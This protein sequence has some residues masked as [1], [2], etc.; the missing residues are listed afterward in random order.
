MVRNGGCVLAAVSLAFAIAGCG[1]SKKKSEA[2]RL[3]DAVVV[4][5]LPSDQMSANA[6]QATVVELTNVMFRKTGVLPQVC[7]KLPADAKAVICLGEAARNVSGVDLSDLRNCDWRIK[8]EPGR[9]YLLGKTPYAINAAMVEFCERFCDVYFI[10]LEGD[11]PCE[12]DPAC[13]V[14]VCDVTVRPAIYCRSIYHGMYEK[15]HYPTTNV[16][17][18]NW[19][20]WSRLRRAEITRDFEGACRVSFQVPQCHSQFYYAHPDKYFKEH[21]EYYS[22][23]RTGRRSAVIDFNSQLCYTSGECL[24]TCYHSLVAFVE[25]DRKRHPTNYPCIYDFS[26]HDNSFELCRCSNC[27][28]VAAKYNRVPGG[29]DKGGDAGLQLEFVNKLAR[30]IRDRY[31]DVQL[32][33]MAY[34][35]TECPPKEG[36]IRPEPNVVVWWCDL[37][38]LSDHTLPLATA[39]HFNEKLADELDGWLALSK[40]VQVWDYMLNTHD[41]PEV[42]PDAIAADARLF[43]KRGISSIFMETEYRKQPFYLLNAFLMSE[44]YINPNLD[45]DALIRTY[46]RIYGAAAREMEEAI[47]LLRR[48]NAGGRAADADAWHNRLLPWLTRENLEAVAA[49]LQKAHDKRGLS[50]SERSRISLALASTWKQIVLILKSDPKA[51][52]EFAVAQ[53]AW[54]RYEK[55]FVRDG[56][57]EE[58]GRKKSAAKVDEELELLTLKFRDLPAELK[59][60][61]EKDLVCVD[62]HHG[63]PRVSD[64]VSERGWAVATKIGDNS[65]A[66]KL[67]MVCGTYDFVAKKGNNYKVEK[68][69]EGGSYSWV[70]LG[71]ATIGRNTNFWFPGSWQSFFSLKGYHIL[72]DGLAEDPNRYVVW[73]SARLKDGR[74]Y[75]DRLV[76]HRVKE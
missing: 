15:R 73:A 8:A 44:L 29:F 50:V 37:Y 19:E 26:Q 18:R 64:P 28:K 21:P 66:G 49:L 68:L 57:M 76:F 59:A 25:A 60:V 62:Y 12:P 16:T 22:M 53:S 30:R 65:F 35:S 11:D 5:T 45:V 67:P 34:V 58:S 40:N 32:R 48:M 51:A 3:A 56:F 4:R 14:P 74:V 70:R 47:Q 36:T 33:I 24:E 43:A 9:V 13:A 41:F 2:I 10:T 1:D 39:G 20:R 63:S 6:I 17:K 54:V 38:T 71:P 7:D 27:R 61:P 75:I 69:V 42:S 52:D 72:A 31:P 23:D 46:C 55:E